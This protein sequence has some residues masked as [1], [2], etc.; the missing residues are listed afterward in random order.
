[1][2]PASLPQMP[3]GVT[4]VVGMSCNLCAEKQTGKKGMNSP[5]IISLI[6]GSLLAT[7]PLEYLLT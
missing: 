1:M 5:H 2:A 7:A 4:Y 6:E 3:E